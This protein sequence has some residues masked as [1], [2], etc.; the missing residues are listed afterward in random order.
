MKRDWWMCAAVLA[1]AVFGVLI[2]VRLAGTVP[3]LQGLAPLMAGL[4]VGVA[5]VVACGG[6]RAERFL[7]GR[8]KWIVFGVATALMLALLVFGPNTTAM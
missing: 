2:Q 6:G 4:L 7:T 8:G 1:L 5:A 3:G